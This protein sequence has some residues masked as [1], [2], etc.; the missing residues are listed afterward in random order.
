MIDAAERLA[1]EEGLGAMSLRAVQTAA[2]QRNKSAAHYHFGSREGLIEAVIIER[3]RPINER[4]AELLAELPRTA[5][6]ADLVDTLVRPLVEA[7][8][9]PEASYW[10]RFVMAAFT[11]PTVADVVQRSLEGRAYRSA[12]DDLLERLDHLPP[13]RRRPRLDSAVALL[14]VSLAALERR[15]TTETPTPTG[16][17]PTEAVTHELVTVCTAVLEAPT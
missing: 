8:L 16:A 6:V 5:S 3:M 1:A 10:A 14:F 12:R 9:K 4:R 2:G 15:A 17:A 13:D 7:I 11:D